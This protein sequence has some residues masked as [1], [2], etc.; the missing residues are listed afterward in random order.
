MTPSLF[1]FFLSLAAGAVVL[2]AIF[3]GVL[4]ISQQDK[5]KRSGR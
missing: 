2:G 1:N 4:V 5:I 3:I